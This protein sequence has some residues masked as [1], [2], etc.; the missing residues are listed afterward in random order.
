MATLPAQVKSINKADRTVELEDG[1]KIPL[2]EDLSY[3]F[4]GSQAAK[5]KQE[6]YRQAIHSTHEALSNLPVVGARTIP[7]AAGYMGLDWFSRLADKGL[8]LATEGAASVFPGEGQEEMGYF[9][10]LGE[11][12]QAKQAGRQQGGE[13][14]GK[15]H[16]IARRVGQGLGFGAGFIAPSPGNFAAQGALMG[17]GL[18]DVN[19]FQNPGEALKEVAIDTTLGFGLGKAGKAL[20]NVAAERKALRQFPELMQQHKQATTKAEKQFIAEMARKLS[21]VEKD[22]RG[23][24]PKASIGANEFINQN[25]GLSPIAGTPEA[26]RL[27]TFF[28]AIENAIPDNFSSSELI[29]VFES[30]EGRIATAAAEE[31]PYLN[32]FKTHLVQSIPIGAA[33][34]AVKTKFGTRIVNSFEKEIDKTLT[35][36]MSDHKMINDVKKV[37][38]KDVFNDLIKDVRK[39]VTTGFEKTTPLEFLEEMKGGNLSERMMSFFENDKKFLTLETKLQGEIDKIINSAIGGTPVS[40]FRGTELQNLIKARDG[41]QN[42]KKGLKTG[43]ENSISSNSLSANIYEND[44]LQKV[45]SKISHATGVQNPF[46]NVPPTNLKNLPIAPNAPQAGRMANFFETPNF[47]SE[48]L[49]KVGSLKGKAGLAKTGLLGSLL[50]GVG[51]AKALA[52]AGAAAGGLT[53]ALRGI[54]SPTAMGAFAR[55]GIQQG[56]IRFIVEAIAERYPSYQ[57]GVLL[58]PQDRR[59][60]ASEVEQD[61]DLGIEDKAILQ[62]KINRGQSIEKL[63]KD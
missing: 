47:Y 22:L 45:S 55:Q 39:S 52:G 16:P 32:A 33:S 48:N 25:I 27:S 59:A 41:I 35:K 14:L 24:I 44:V 36:F 37:V 28:R 1:R 43:L 30:I 62:T 4:F 60:A 49:K 18:S 26:T 23:G 13:E 8:S 56:G 57:D 3:E 21:A 38:G 7:G 10:R 29:K 31:I 61:P 15:K 42:M 34:N 53:A 2:P 20:E 6:G 63:I 46:S 17:A 12:Y 9:Q 54:T 11:N 58:D 19:P 5:N 50:M 51:G 40:R